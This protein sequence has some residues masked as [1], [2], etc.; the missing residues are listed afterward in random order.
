MRLRASSRSSPSSRITPS[1]SPHRPSSN[2]S[3]RQTYP[4]LQTQEGLT[5]PR[6]TRM[7]SKLTSPSVMPPLSALR[8]NNRSLHSLCKYSSRLINSWISLKTTLGMR[9]RTLRL[10]ISGLIRLSK[11]TSIGVSLL[12]VS[13]IRYL[14][15][16]KR[17]VE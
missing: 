5:S 2:S 17:A 13:Q 9:S 10:L 7:P 4:R 1:Q 3:F 16:T 11:S 8:D 12:R 6:S 14:S 15:Q